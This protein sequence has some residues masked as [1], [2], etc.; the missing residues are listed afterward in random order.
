VTFGFSSGNVRSHAFSSG[1]H[2]GKAHTPGNELIYVRTWPV[3]NTFLQD[4]LRKPSG[5]VRPKTVFLRKRSGRSRFS[6]GKLRALPEASFRRYFLKEIP[7]RT[8]KS[9]NSGLILAYARYLPTEDI[10]KLD[11]EYSSNYYYSSYQKDLTTHLI[12]V[13]ILLIILVYRPVLRS[14]TTRHDF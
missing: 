14:R 7:S 11:L 13:V 8:H 2:P 12:V 3:F 4:S 5:N 9:T 10:F 1:K 6:S